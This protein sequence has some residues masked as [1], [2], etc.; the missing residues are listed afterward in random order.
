MKLKKKKKKI[1][2]VSAREFRGNEQVNVEPRSK[3][4]KADMTIENFY[5]IAS[6]YL[7]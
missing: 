4:E 3:E 2:K 7:H 5:A 6:L 1:L